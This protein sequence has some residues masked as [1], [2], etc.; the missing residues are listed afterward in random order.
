MPRLSTFLGTPIRH[1][2][3]YPDRKLRLARRS[4]R[5]RAEGGRVHE[6][7]LVDGP[8][9]RLA[10]PLRHDT[11]RDLNDA[12]QKTLLYARLSAEDRFERGAR[13]GVLSLVVRPPLELLRSYVLKLGFLDGAAGLAVALLHALSYALRAAFLIELRHGRRMPSEDVR[14]APRAPE[15]VPRPAEE[16]GR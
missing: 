13:G 11:Y 1:G 3:W 6:R 2:T 15:P 4:R 5:F 10:T 8:V 16:I 7:L 9:E 14:R 12:L